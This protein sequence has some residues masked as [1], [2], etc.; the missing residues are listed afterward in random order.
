MSRDSI[1]LYV[2]FVVLLFVIFG[3]T[4]ASNQNL[5]KKPVILVTSAG[6]NRYTSEVDNGWLSAIMDGHLRLRLIAL[7]NFHTIMPDSLN[8]ALVERGKKSIIY[9][10][11]VDWKLINAAGKGLRADLVINAFY[12]VEKGDT[13]ALSFEVYSVKENKAVSFYE[14]RFPAEETGYHIDSCFFTLCKS[15]GLT[16]ESNEARKVFKDISTADIKTMKKIGNAWVGYNRAS[17]NKQKMNSYA[18]LAEVN[19]AYPVYGVGTYLRGVAAEEEKVFE[20][21]A[22]AYNTL[23][24]R[25]GLYYP[26]LYVKVLRNFRLSSNNGQ[27]GRTITIAEKKGVNTPAFIVEKARLLK[28][29]RKNDEALQAY[30][31]ALEI[32]PNSSEAIFAMAELS[33]ENGNKQEALSW[34]NKER[35]INGT[36]EKSLKKIVE[37]S[38]ALGKSKE[39]KGDLIEL[40]KIDSG[41][42]FANKQMA[43]ISLSEGNFSKA[44]SYSSKIVMQPNNPFFRELAR[45]YAKVGKTDNAVDVYQ[46]YLKSGV[47]DD[48]AWIE[49]AKIYNKTGNKKL[50]AEACESA[51]RINKRHESYYK[52]A[53]DYYYS[54]KDTIKAKRIYEKLNNSGLKN[55]D[56]SFKLATMSFNEKNYTK[57]SQYAKNLS[58]KYK[59]KKIVKEILAHSDFNSG[60]Y[61]NALKSILALLKVSPYDS[62]I[63]LMAAQCYEKTGNAQSAINQYKKYLKIKGAP[64]KREYA[65]NLVL[66]YEKIKQISNAKTLLISNIS[67]YPKDTR[68]HLKLMGYYK[69]SNKYSSLITLGKKTLAVSSDLD[70]VIILM[71]ESYYKLKQYENAY[72]AYNKYLVKFPNKTEI[73]KKC[74][75]LAF[76][77]GK[78]LKCIEHYNF[79]L[80]SSPGTQKDYFNLAECYY[81]QKDYKGAVQYYNQVLKIDS[82]NVK[83]LSQ[84]T[85]CYTTLKDTSALINNL[86]KRIAITKSPYSLKTQLGKLYV[87]RNMNDLAISLYEGMLKEKANDLKARMVLIDLYLNKKFIANAKKHLD[88][89]LRQSPKNVELRMSKAKCHISLNEIPMAKTELEK[90]ISIKP[91]LHN[92]RFMYAGILKDQNQYTAALSQLKKAV[93]YDKK[94]LTYLLAASKVALKANQKKTALIYMEKA[95]M[96]KPNDPK[97]IEIAGIVYAANGNYIKAKGYL[98]EAIAS[99]SFSPDCAFELGKIYFIEKNFQKAEPQLLYAINKDK[100]NWEALYMVGDIAY[101]TRKLKSA[102]S[103]YT[104]TFTLNSSD[105]EIFF[106]LIK[107][108]LEQGR[109]KEA[110]NIVSN[111][112]KVKN[113]GWSA[114]ARAL[115]FE[116]ENKLGDAYNALSVAG[117][118]IP[119][120]KDLEYAKGRVRFKEKKYKSALAHFKTLAT[121]K[122]SSAS[123]HYM[124][125]DS[126]QKLGQYKSASVSFG[127]SLKLNPKQP[128]VYFSMG[129]MAERRNNTKNAITH[130]SQA[131]KYD[132]SLWEAY[133]KMAAIQRKLKDW[134]NAAENYLNAYKYSKKK[135]IGLE[136]Y[137]KAGDIYFFKISEPKKAK[138]CYK[139]YIKLGGTDKVIKDRIDTI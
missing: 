58:S 54:T 87:S 111:S 77:T 9:G 34:Y 13:V 99:R 6:E 68:N 120:N 107:T 65:Y 118:F 81:N 12:E 100:S 83:S 22:R 138:K 74:A 86:K 139:K 32:D 23:T 78:Y 79:L 31:Q 4:F 97:V 44:S 93:S 106:K 115:V 3:C 57:A 53:G 8:T 82:L 84:L 108:C 116:S 92:A 5:K 72:N 36:S 114:F 137:K 19:D 24:L 73:R 62:D 134:N 66:L 109:F 101:S 122:K 47:R 37:L 75:I 35:K 42:P 125:G 18:K 61:K 76:D 121:Y 55:D 69:S 60:N 1:K 56:I 135:D 15:A 103:Y 123:Y 27:A 26:K 52:D 70:T 11:E 20:D 7:D 126:Y 89:A 33:E 119:E 49:I 104:Q 130:Y 131:V 90:I 14:G 80:A 40:L 98:E 64:K 91:S 129:E 94:N 17:N 85:S 63:V 28:K 133:Y 102:E 16:W 48:T 51:Y 112:T 127:K 110:Q 113:D 105:S 50:G 39:V 41:D 29:M 2:K 38:I 128:S 136:A 95:L 117:K 96:M 124:M 25:N 59:N 71:A 30:K 10:Q 67:K 88:A 45:G 46:R 21:A 43:L 132:V